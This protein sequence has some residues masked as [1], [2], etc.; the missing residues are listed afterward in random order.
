MVG[1]VAVSFVKL[2]VLIRTYYMTI[3]SPLNNEPNIIANYNRTINYMSKNN[4]TYK[5]V[6]VVKKTVLVSA[7]V[8]NGKILANLL[9]ATVNIPPRL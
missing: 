3:Q 2:A 4:K 9:F 1:V 7:N 5:E 8:K 6:L